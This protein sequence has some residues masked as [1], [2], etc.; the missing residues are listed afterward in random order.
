M[1]DLTFLGI[2]GSVKVK[3]D[4]VPGLSGIGSSPI[5]TVLVIENPF[6]AILTFS[7]IP[8]KTHSTR[9]IGLTC[10]KGPALS[11]E[12][13]SEEKPLELNESWVD[14]AK[15]TAHLNGIVF[16]VATK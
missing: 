6:A 2:D 11:K 5:S 15:G 12:T 8:E 9:G 14:V 3:R 7:E 1:K 13:H 16:H 4:T 10:G